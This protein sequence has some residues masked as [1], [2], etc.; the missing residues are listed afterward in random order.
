MTKQNDGG[1]AFPSY[2]NKDKGWIDGM[3]LR[4]YFAGQALVGLI[5][6]LRIELNDGKPTLI[7]ESMASEVAYS[8]AD[9]TIKQ[10]D[11]ILRYR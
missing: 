3:S 1:T 9:A 5:Q 2:T 10:N 7:K 6:S 4:D 11:L 8:Y